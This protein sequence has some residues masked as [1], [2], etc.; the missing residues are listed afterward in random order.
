M[1]CVINENANGKKNDRLIQSAVNWAHLILIYSHFK[2]F[3][4]NYHLIN[5]HLN[6]KKKEE[7]NEDKDEQRINE[8]KK[9][10]D[11]IDGIITLSTMQCKNDD[12]QRDYLTMF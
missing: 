5:P 2:I 7:E 6:F 12:D 11:K 10:R 8:K 3:S 9:K 4:N 1:E